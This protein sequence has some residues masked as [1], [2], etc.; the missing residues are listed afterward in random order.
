MQIKYFPETD[1]LIIDFKDE[2]IVES[3]HLEDLDIVVD[4]NKDD[5]IISI[6]IFNFSKRTEKI[7]ELSFPFQGGLKKVQ[8]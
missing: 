5:E 2:P 1:T 7:N 3:E 6:E 8:D 4:Y